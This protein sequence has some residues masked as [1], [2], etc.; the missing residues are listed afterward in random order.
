MRLEQEGKSYTTPYYNKFHTEI[1]YMYK[2]SKVNMSEYFRAE[3]S[4]FVSVMRRT[5]E[6]DTQNRF[7]TF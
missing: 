2:N 1:M 4:Q 6:K 5:I 7:E 3:L